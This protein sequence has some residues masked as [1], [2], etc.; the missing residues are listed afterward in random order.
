MLYKQLL[1]WI[2]QG[3]LF[4][5]YKEFFIV[6]EA[7]QQQQQQQRPDA[8]GR[9]ASSHLLGGSGDNTSTNPSSALTATGSGGKAT[10]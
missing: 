5:P 6:E 8:T 4:D 3:R 10:K 7:Q 9:T 1:G 2:L